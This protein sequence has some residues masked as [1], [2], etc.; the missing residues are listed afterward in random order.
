MRAVLDGLAVRGLRRVFVEGGGITVSR[1]LEQGCLQ[2]LQIAIAPLVLGAGRPGISFEQVR[3][4][5]DGLRPP[6]RHF[7]QGDDMLFDCDLA[8]GCA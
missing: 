2:R 6:T 5:R 1:F 8:N 3:A 4:L 7:R